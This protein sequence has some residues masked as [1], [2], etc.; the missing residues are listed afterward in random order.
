M[1][2]ATPSAVD[3]VAVLNRVRHMLDSAQIENALEVLVASGQNCPA[4]ANA[5]G[6]CLLR[7]GKPEEAAKIFCK[8]VFPHDDFTIPEDV[9][10][11]FRINYATAW[12]LTG[13]FVA[14][15]D[16]LKQISDHSHP[17]VQRLKT[18]VRQWKRSL[19]WWR[20]MLLPIGFYPD[21]PLRLDFLPGE[22]WLPEGIEGPRPMERA[23]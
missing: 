5:K 7:L 11:T 23:A 14:G 3:T 12:F 20:R 21:K 6:V 19:P 4:I 13:D 17:A 1:K 18:A 8:L 16:L 9:P 10:T 15:S 2:R 22:L